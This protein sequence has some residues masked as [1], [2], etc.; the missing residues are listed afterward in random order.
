MIK[1]IFSFIFTASLAILAPACPPSNPPT[2]HTTPVVK[3]TAMCSDADVHITQLCNA[4]HIKNKY[5][6]DVVAPT[7]KGKSFTQF[8]TEKQNEGLF[9]NPSC[10]A[11]VTSCEQI[12]VCT[13]SK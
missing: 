3:D 10:L 5:C 6:C 12:N 2:P 11:Q 7:K 13:N 8:C 9:L 1:N 4:D